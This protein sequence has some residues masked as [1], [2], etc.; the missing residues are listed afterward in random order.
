M[1]QCFPSCFADELPSHDQMPNGLWVHAMFYKVKVLVYLLA[2]IT[3]SAC[4][5][6]S[7]ESVYEGVRGQQKINS[8]P[9]VPNPLI[10]P[11]YDQYKKEREQSSKPN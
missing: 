6:I 10:L 7:P 5:V 8:D 4:G 11:T 3:I 2:L 1:L 9:A